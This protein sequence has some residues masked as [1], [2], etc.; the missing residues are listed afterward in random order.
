MTSKTQKMALQKGVDYQIG[1]NTLKTKKKIQRLLLKW[2]GGEGR[3]MT[4]QQ[5]SNFLLK[6]KKNIGVKISL[7]KEE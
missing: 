1:I 3:R 4:F 5:T 6:K 2:G 7:K